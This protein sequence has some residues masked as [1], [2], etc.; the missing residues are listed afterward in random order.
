MHVPAGDALHY[1]DGS[2]R[3]VPA[4]PAA[5]PEGWRRV[6]EAHIQEAAAAGGCDAPRQRARPRPAS[7]SPGWGRVRG[8]RSGEGRGVRSGEGPASAA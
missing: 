1:S 8:V 3:W 5:D 4:D 6:I 7:G 2:H